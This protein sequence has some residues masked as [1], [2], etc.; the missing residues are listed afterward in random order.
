L[1]RED[2]DLHALHLLAD[3]APALLLLFLFQIFLLL[4]YFGV[5][6]LGDLTLKPLLHEERRIGILRQAAAVLAVWIQL[7]QCRRELRRLGRRGKWSGLLAVD[8]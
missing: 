2:L 7:V 6:I 5:L 3:L 8:E 1:R 4:G